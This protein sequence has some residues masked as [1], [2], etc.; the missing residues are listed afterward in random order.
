MHLQ[1]CAASHGIY[2]DDIIVAGET[3]LNLDILEAQADKAGFKLWTVDD[4]N[5]RECMLIL[6]RINP[7]ILA[8][9]VP[10][11]LREEI[12]NKPTV[13]AVNAHAGILP[14][15]RGVDSR[16]WAILEGGELGVT[17]HIVD[18]GVDTGPVLARTRLELE[19]GDT[20]ATLDRRNYYQNKWQTLVEALQAIEEGHCEPQEQALEDG[21][22]YFWMHRE[23]R[24]IVDEFLNRGLQGRA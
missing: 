6:D 7:D 21:K 15:Y 11:I 3:D 20:V 9:M 23:L 4:P 19:K 22:Q 24:C 5:S 14:E 18:A 2:F 13:G 1:Y 8:I 10:T 12:I 17:A 16:R